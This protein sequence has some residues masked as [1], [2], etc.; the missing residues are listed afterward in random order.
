[1]TLVTILLALALERTVREFHGPRLVVEWF[2][3]FL[4]WFGQRWG[5]TFNS[6]FGVF[7]ALSAP[8]LAVGL[9]YLAVKTSFALFGVIFSIL[10][11]TSCLGFNQLCAQVEDFLD[12]RE[13]GD[14]EGARIEAGAIAEKTVHAA[15]E[16]LTNVTLDAI[17]VQA[18]ERFFGV[19]LWFILFG[20]A[21]AILFRLACVMRRQVVGASHVFAEAAEHF[22][23]VLG[24]APARFAGLAYAVAGSYTHAM[25]RWSEEN[26]KGQDSNTAVLITSG[27]GALLTYHARDDD[28][29]PAEAALSL[30]KRA[31]VVWITIVALFTVGGW[32]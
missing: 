30:V 1:M 13:R 14:E 21:G 16:D 25:Q 9:L 32:G 11:L 31:V 23:W 8:A 27:R 22:H 2:V 17:L 28:E 6:S 15:G 19:V 3:K 20:P 12:M 26:E 18:N 4:V 10:V 29:D 5:S 7:L 24:W